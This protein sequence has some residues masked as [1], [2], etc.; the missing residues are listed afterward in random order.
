MR[1]SLLRC[2]R[3]PSPS[4]TFSSAGND[5]GLAYSYRSRIETK[6]S[7]GS[8]PADRQRVEDFA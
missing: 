3:K 2:V 8:T 7:S 6:V 5:V 4:R 1:S